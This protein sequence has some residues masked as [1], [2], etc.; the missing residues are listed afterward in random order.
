MTYCLNPKCQNPQNPNQ[1]RF[2]AYCGHRLRLGGRFRA[3]RLISIGGMGR[4]F[5]GVDEADDSKTKCII[6]QL[7]LQNQDTNNAQKAAESFRQEATRLQV[8]GQH[9]QIPE[10]LAYFEA[11][12][13]LGI[14]GEPAL[15]HKYI[16]GES[17]ATELE[18][19]GTFRE[20]QV[21]Q[22]LI[23]LLPVLRFIHSHQVIHRDINPHNII[24]RP[25]PES[26]LSKLPTRKTRKRFYSW[27]GRGSELFLVDFSAAKLTTKTVLARTGT[28]IGSAAYTASEQL[29]GKAIATSDL[30][31]LGVTCI[32]LLTNVHPFDMFNSL[33]G[34]WVWVDYLRQPVSEQLIRILN[35]MVENLPDQR[36]QSAIQVLAA[37]GLPE[38]FAA[39]P[40]TSLSTTVTPKFDTPTWKC[41]HTFSEESSG[42]NSIAFSPN[43]QTIVS[44]S[45]DKTITIFNWQA[46]TV[47]AK[48]SGHLNVIEAVGFSPDGEIIASSSWDHTIKL[49]HGYTGN[50][51]HT[52]CGHSAW[53][54][55]LA[56]SHNGQLIASG[57]ADQ[58]IKLWML[59][60][61]SLQTTLFGHL[62][63]VNT[64]AISKDGQLLA[65]GSADKTIKLWNLVT[66]K[67][68]ATI[69]GHSASVESLTFSPSG[70]ILIS[71]SADKTI[72][73]W[74][75]KRDR[76]LQIPKKPLLTLTGHGN[77]VKS[78]AIS[79]QGN[80]LISGS[81]DKTV[82]IWHP[83]S[84]ELLYTLTDHLSAVTT[85]AISHDG[86]TIASSS[87][88]NTIKIWQFV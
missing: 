83:G 74:L 6:K 44:G 7:S 55:C 8:L 59:K 52:L 17:L 20:N 22:V 80:T 45:T 11:D 47:V 35:K 18:T 37:L 39:I 19:E 85:V 9:P 1:A 86:A 26:S 61:A 54:K 50:L 14:P 5:L 46:K 40:V 42:I 13:Q 81:A 58:T 15:V 62:G 75:L 28:M 43:G 64:V 72:K 57:S 76:Y 41:V 73:I 60:K 65:S 3:L 38:D 48:L 63:T 68:A 82:K 12:H 66:G 87:Q 29:M 77:A 67:L 78:I 34:K 21:R 10:L 51:I 32:H 23:E 88:D 36:Y 16:E 2:C 79:P 71:G 4:T 84:G 69:T 33:E 49:W 53:V 31:S 24:R 30:Y 56:I 25:P 27:G 70:Q